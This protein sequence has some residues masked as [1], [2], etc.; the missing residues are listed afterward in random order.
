MIALVIAPGLNSGLEALNKHYPTPLL[1]LVDRPFIQHAVEFLIGQGVTRFEFILSHLPEKIEALLGDGSRWGTTF[2]YHLAQDPLLPYEPLKT[3]KFDN[4]DEILLLAHADQLPQIDLKKAVENFQSGGGTPT[5]WGNPSESESPNEWD[6]TG[7]ALIPET[8]I[9]NIPENTDEGHLKTHF[10]SQAKETALWVTVSQQLNFQ[11]YEAILMSHRALLKKEFTGLFLKGAE[12][13]DGIWISRNVSLHPTT[14]IESP[15]YIDEDCRIGSGVQLGP[16]C[17]IG[18]ECVLDSGSI[19][20]N[21]VIFSNTY[22]GDGLELKDV[23]VDK[24]RL[25]N[26]RFGTAVSIPENFILGGVSASTLG[27]RLRTVIS[28]IAA[29]VLLLLIWPL[30][31]GVPLVLK[32]FRR[33]PAIFKKKVVRLPTQADDAFWRT[34]N[35]L[36]FLPHS[37]SSLQKREPPKNEKLHHL[38]FQFLP[39]LVCI[40]KGNLHF[41]GVHPRS[42]EEIEALSPDWKDLYLKSKPGIITEAYVNYGET[43]TEDELYTAEVFYSSTQ[44]LGHDFKLFASYI[45]GI[46]SR[47]G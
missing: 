20:E 34:F 3:L 25:I 26:T 37:G 17:V 18:K 9:K 1:P 32:L 41:V 40:A 46:F 6:W 24:N 38:I 36:S 15:V 33:G 22:V 42:K 44:G 29:C 28:Q 45:R 30:L 14:K 19:V 12:A 39:A 10:L 21:A 5:F 31:L 11:T 47:K 2:R 13:E 8:Y 43:P 16:N 4:P 27:R 35:F 7:W 23:I